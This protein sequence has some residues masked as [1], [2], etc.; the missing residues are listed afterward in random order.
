M[1]RFRDLCKHSLIKAIISETR[2]SKRPGEKYL[3]SNFGYCL[4]GQVIEAV[5]HV[6][7]QEYVQREILAQ[8]GISLE[9]AENTPHGRKHDEVAYYGQSGENPYTL[10]VNRMDSDGGWLAHARDLVVFISCLDTSGVILER[11]TV[12]EMVKG[13]IKRGMDQCSGGGESYYAHGW[14]VDDQR[15]ETWFHNGSLPGSTTVMKRIREGH[16]YAALT[17][18]RRQ[19]ESPMI[20]KLFQTVDDMAA[21]VPEWQS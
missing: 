9:L 20:C 21:R 5:S 11:Q 1:Y 16:S 19:P 18:T 15:P 7:Y 10:N 2:L 12:S 3:Y 17:N 13:Q 14:V 4:L 8:C 6:D